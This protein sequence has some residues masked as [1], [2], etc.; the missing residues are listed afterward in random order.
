MPPHRPSPAG[1]VGAI[2]LADGSIFRS[3]HLPAASPE[4]IR[5][6]R[7]TERWLGLEAK[8]TIVARIAKHDAPGCPSPA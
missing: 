1:V 6:T 8:A 2:F 3:R 7:S 4:F 5:P